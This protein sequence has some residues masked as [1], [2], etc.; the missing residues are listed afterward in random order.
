MNVFRLAA[1][2][3]LA[4]SATILL[5]QPPAPAKDAAATGPLAVDVHTSPYRAKVYYSMNLGHQR[6]DMRDASILDLI[7]FAY[8]REE[9]AVLG[10][11]PGS[12]GTASIWLPAS[13]HL[14]LRDST[15]TRRAPP[16]PLP[17]L[18]IR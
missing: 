17:T 15:P 13:P 8:D 9:D 16:V 5:A 3:L 7:T 2:L 18:T 6:F 12:T 11:P 4:P 1:A 10:V 14:S